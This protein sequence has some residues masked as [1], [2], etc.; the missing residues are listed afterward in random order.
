MPSPDEISTALSRN[1]KHLRTSLGL[2][3]DALTRRSGVSKGML[4]QIEQAKVNPSVGTLV[5]V[6]DALGTSIARL[7]DL[8]DRPRV[9]VVENDEQ[10][11]LWK[12]KR[13]GIGVLVCGSDRLEHIE[14]WSWRMAPSEGHTSD[15]HPSGTEEFLYVIDGSLTL[16]VGEER[17]F[18]RRGSS[19]MFDA[20]YPHGY[21]NKDRKRALRFIMFT[22]T[23]NRFS[24]RQS[25]RISAG[26]AKGRRHGE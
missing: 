12:G 3:L 26:P 23:P 21:F 10:A 2:S 5:K 6:A 22:V 19:V 8:G 11:P 13:G 7:V 15:P 25:R 18:V 24:L 20:D 17:Y 4:V 9:R 1:L 14:N 16:K